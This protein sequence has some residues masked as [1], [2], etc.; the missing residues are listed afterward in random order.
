VR[1]ATSHNCLV[2]KGWGRVGQVLLAV[3]ALAALGVPATASAQ[4]AP[5]A[6]ANPPSLGSIQPGGS[7][8]WHGDGRQVLGRP[9]VYRGSSGGVELAWMD[10]TLLRPVFVPGTGDPGGPWG[11]GGQVAPEVRSQLVAA[12]NGGFKMGD[13]PGGWFAEGRTLKSLVPGQASLVIYRDGH[14]TVGEWGRDVDLTPDVVAVRQNLGL[15]V[16]GGRPVAAA[17]SPGAWGAS[18]AGV[19]TA[20]SGI[21][22]DAN[23][24][25]VSAQ[26]R[27]SPQGLA[28][29][30]VAAGAVRG[31]QLDINPDWTTFVLYDVNPDGSVSG[32]KVMGSGGP[33][34]QYLSPY[35]RDFFAMLIRPAVAPGGTGEI[36]NAPVKATVTKAAVA[37]K[38]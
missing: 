38:H 7:V 20:R 35:A 22:V 26:A 30:L 37:A 24:A 8:A 16:D 32:R 21:G 1:V 5:A 18:V 31:M 6:P 12:F 27:V 28:D 17:G 25:L 19:A 33:G 36:G 2:R 29:A 34:G 23:G 13:I 14:A 10:P 4:T 15:L 3:G 9:V 11:W